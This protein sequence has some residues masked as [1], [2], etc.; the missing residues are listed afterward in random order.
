MQVT[1]KLRNGPLEGTWTAINIPVGGTDPSR[2]NADVNSG[3]W[4]EYTNINGNTRSM[5]FYFESKYAPMTDSSIQ[6]AVNL[7]LTNKDG[8][9]QTYG[10]ISNWNTCGVTNMSYLFNKTGGADFNDDISRWDTSNVTNMIQMFAGAAKFNQDIGSWDTSNVTKMDYMFS[11]AAKFDQDIGSWDTSNVNSMTGMFE[12]ASN[13][14]TEFAFNQDIGSW[15]TS[16][17]NIMDKMFMTNNLNTH[18]PIQSRPKCVACRQCNLT[19]RFL[20]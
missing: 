20:C 17:V 16:N 14:T 4:W 10:D 11:D 3:S 9:T 2:A 18:I 15:D 19:Y 1:V 5:S 12:A 8:A 13:S 7:W 6:T